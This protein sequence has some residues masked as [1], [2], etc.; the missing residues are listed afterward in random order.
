MAAVVG[1]GQPCLL[2]LARGGSAAPKENCSSR[3][4]LWALVSGRAESVRMLDAAVEIT[5]AALWSAAGEAGRGGPRRAG[6]EWDRRQPRMS[7]RRLGRV[8]GSIFRG[9][10]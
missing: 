5:R 10:G 3:W 4:C 9:W 1:E 2:L 7:Q 8:P 6:T